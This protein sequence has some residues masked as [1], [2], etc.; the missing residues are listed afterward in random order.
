MFKK[1][2]FIKFDTNNV[3]IYEKNEKLIPLVINNLDIDILYDKI[4]DYVYDLFAIVVHIGNN[5][6]F[7]HYKTYCRKNERYWYCYDD[8]NLNKV[9]INDQVIY[10]KCCTNGYIL[11]YERR[12]CE[13]NILNNEPNNKTVK[14]TPPPV[15]FEP[16]IAT[17]LLEL[18]DDDNSNLYVT[19]QMNQ[20][21]LRNVDVISDI[22]NVDT[23]KETNSFISIQR[24]KQGLISF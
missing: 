5:V 23:H 10:N 6:T 24:I 4:T 19:N 20:L 17:N 22:T 3:A 16:H 2:N 12:L 21:N 9:N 15:L 8:S 18:D 13:T 1:I 14:I 7:G 11:F